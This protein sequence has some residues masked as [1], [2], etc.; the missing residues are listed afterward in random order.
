MSHPMTQKK[1]IYGLILL[2][3]AGEAAFFLPF[4]IQRVFRPTFLD[5]FG[6]T[7]YQL[8]ICFSVYGLVALFSYFFGGTLA[9]RFSPR[10]LMSSALILTAFGGVWMTFYPGYL[11]MQW[12]YGYWGFTTV[13]MFWGAII[14]QTRIW[15]GL[16]NQGIAFGFL[17]G[18]RGLVAA[19]LSSLG[20]WIYAGYVSKQMEISLADRQ[21]AFGAVILITSAIVALVGVLVFLFL[22][23][24]IHPI[25]K[26]PMNTIFV[27]GH[28]K[29][30]LKIPSIWWLSLVIL[31]AYM[32]Y[33][34]S[35]I[36]SLYAKEVMKYDEVQAAGIGSLLLYLRPVVGILIGFMADKTR[37]SLMIFWGFFL[38]LIGSLVFATG[39]IDP[40]LKPLF[41][42]GIGLS[43]IGTYAARAVYFAILQ[44]GSIPV[45]LT[46]TAVGVVSFIGY[47]PDIFSGPLI[48]FLLDRS[49]GE[50]GHREVFG[51]LSLFALVG[52]FATS[53]FRKVSNS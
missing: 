47:T 20:V 15:G 2:I 14:K 10:I 5:V 9:D 8:G 44:E 3:L 43:A 37:G 49:P 36:F 7:N 45:I 11:G 38:M 32:G 17:D 30:V 16:D 13:F 39:V 22:D 12:L 40:G 34:V 35:D 18:G 52:M 51:L 21:Q 48:G 19:I 46:G 42:I 27:W 6:L 1:S 28:F 33:K 31:C 24:P 26:V 50:Q 25:K 4:V 23:K 53:A 41:F 29:K